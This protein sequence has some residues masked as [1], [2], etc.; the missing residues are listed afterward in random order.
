MLK[1]LIQVSSLVCTLAIGTWIPA[2]ASSVGGSG[3]EED[4]AA[5]VG[6]FTSDMPV[7]ASLKF[8]GVDQRCRHE[9]VAMRSGDDLSSAEHTAWRSNGNQ[10]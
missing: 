5:P 10:R 3:N 7:P 8:A 6:S 1:K 2:N 4:A 9:K